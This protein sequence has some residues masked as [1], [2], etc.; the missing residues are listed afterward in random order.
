MGNPTQIAEAGIGAN[1]AGGVLGA[2][3][4]EQSGEAQ[5]GMYNYQAGVAQ[6]NATIAKQNADY[7]INSGEQQAQSYGLQAGNRQGQIVASQSSSGLDV[8]SGSNKQVQES[9]KMVTNLDLTQIRSNANK[10]AYDF[11]NQAVGFESQATLDTMAGKN[12]A[13]A[14]TIGAFS[15]ILGSASSVSSKWLQGNQLGLFGNSSSPGWSSGFDT[16]QAGTL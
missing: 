6:L 15:S 10:T 3:G 9:Q 13:E 7:A 1:A 12:A 16:N 11:E 14:G 5:Q 4:S 8:N 2:I